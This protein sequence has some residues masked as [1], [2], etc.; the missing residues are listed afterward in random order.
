MRRGPL[1]VG[2]VALVLTLAGCG[3]VSVDYEETGIDGLTVP[4]PTPDP[5]DFVGE[6]DNPWLPLEPGSTWTSVSYTH[7]TLPTILRV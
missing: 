4:T 3:S 7:L 2:V 6:V 1:S 5:E